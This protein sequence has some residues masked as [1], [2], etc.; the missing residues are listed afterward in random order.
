[1][2]FRLRM[3]WLL[4]TRLYVNTHGEE[5]LL[6]LNNSKWNNVN[7]LTS[8]LKLFFCKL[9]YPIFT[10]EMYNIFI[11]EVKSICCTFLW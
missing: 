5:F 10:P 4:V 9:L 7:I 11:V 1:M 8:L 3:P 6:Q 2:L